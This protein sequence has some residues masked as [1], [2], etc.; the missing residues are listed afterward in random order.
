M[1]IK[2]LFALLALSLF[3]LPYCTKINEAT[4]LGDDLIPAVDNVKTFETALNVEAAFFPYNDS[5]KALFGES[6]AIGKLN[7]PVFGTT[8]ADMY[9]NLSSTVYGTR[10]F[11]D[12]ASDITI[13]SVV[14]SLALTAGYGDTANSQIGVQIFEN[15][16]NNGFVDT[17]LYR[18]DQPSF[19]TTGAVLGS[20]NFSV[21][22][23][24]D[25]FQI[26]PTGKR[27]DSVK[28]ANVLRIPLAKS[29]GAKLN[30]FDTTSSLTTG[31]YKA[32]SIFRMLFRG[33]AVKTTGATG[34]GS[35]AY[36]NLSDVSKSGLI[37][38]YRNKNGSTSD[39]ATATFVHSTY[40]QANSIIRLPGGEYAAKMGQTASQKLY[41]QSSPTGS[42]VGIKIPGL[43]TFSNKVI[44]RAEL[45]AY[46]VPA[47]NPA[48]DNVFATPNRLLLDHKGPTN[49]KDSAYIFDN[50]IETGIDGSLNFAAFGGS[51]RSDATY[52]FTL[53]RY[54]QGIVTR[55]ERNDSLRLFA[56]LRANQYS[57]TLSQVISVPNLDY[58]ARGRVVIAGNNYPDP[59]KRLRLRIVYS[60]L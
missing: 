54:V 41:I 60:N 20:K 28:V 22:Q 29:I 44:H 1:K 49:T 32:D 33:L 36:F 15:A 6:L 18:F 21:A 4:E 2:G 30:S 48:F 5:S 42:Y 24:R 3:L 59:T 56:P 17:T 43:D 13:D 14:L 11:N 26:Y 19:S 53:T 40:T 7:D 23:L 25:S 58:I 8:S 51:L 52:R 10:P 45:I 12:T 50:D 39:T 46:R 34:A 31:G 55:K 27:T 16:Q 57:K 9:F 35:L 37:V 47:D 38:Y